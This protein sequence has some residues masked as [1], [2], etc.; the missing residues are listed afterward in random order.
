MGPCKPPLDS[1]PASSDVVDNRQKISIK[2]NEAEVEKLLRLS[3]LY[4]DS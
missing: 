3:I 1:M 2:M 4:I